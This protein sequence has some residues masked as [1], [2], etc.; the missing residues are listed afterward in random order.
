MRTSDS[1]RTMCG[2]QCGVDSQHP[3]RWKGHG[4]C[5]RMSQEFQC[6]TRCLAFL[7]STANHRLSRRSERCE[8]A[9][10]RPWPSMSCTRDT[11]GTGW[12]LYQPGRSPKS[13]FCPL[14]FSILKRFG[15][16]RQCRCCRFHR[17]R[18]RI[19]NPGCFP[20]QR[21][22]GTSRFQCRRQGEVRYRIGRRH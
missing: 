8:I 18:L 10:S 17:S 5:G 13:R 11:T 22:C 21:C 19:H 6:S 7:S 1:D 12:N 9:P 3:L 4:P 16:G 15:L 20:S 2:R 14:R